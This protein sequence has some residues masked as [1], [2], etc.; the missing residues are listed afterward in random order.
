MLEKVDLTKKIE[1][2]EYKNIIEKL[3]LKI[4]ELQREAKELKIPVII[5][6]EGWKAAGKGTLI[7]EL[8][9]P[10][11]PR[12]FNV[13]P[14]NPPNEEESLRP[15]LWRFWIKTPAKGRIALF[16]R[17]WY[18]RVLT[19][20]I[21]NAVSK[22]DWKLAY[23]EIKSFERQLADAGNV[24]IKLFLHIDKKEQ[25]KRF[26]KLLENKSTSWKI[27]KVDMKA[28]KQYGE[29]LKVFDDMIAKTD[30]DYAPWTIVESHDK[31]FALVK[32][33][34]T[35]IE[36]LENKIAQVKKSKTEKTVKEKTRQSAESNVLNSSILDKIDLSQK[37]SKEDYKINLEQ[38]QKR[39]RE[40]E[41]EIYI[42]RIPVIIMFE[43]WDAAGKGGAI[44]RLTQNMDPR[45]YE[46]IPIAAPN[47]IEKAHHY[48]W[49]FWNAIPKAGHICIFDRTWYGRVLVERIEGFCSTEDWKRAYKEINETEEHLTNH[50]AVVV[51]FWLHIDKDEQMRRFQE[52][53]KLEYKQ[54]KITDEDWRNREKWD[55]YKSAVDELL[56]RT[57]PVNAPW[58]V[59]EANDKL[60][61]R[62]KILKTVI[63]AADKK[64]KKKNG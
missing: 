36:S 39:L 27:T 63:D 58:T 62:I 19:D 3:E 15:F 11:D 12:G 44:R 64:L 45:G 43:G 4:G 9:L 47:D 54:W 40:I 50:G 13:Y 51:K 38:Y 7:N 48:L 26:D 33:Y 57:S 61:A 41:H 55:A 10:L 8:I 31:R 60:F 20:R 30:T 59:V 6:F 24:I 53:Q 32:I 42:R 52:R 22:K 5:V 17:S 49:R 34:K 23:D 16:D 28:Q 56:F 2:E 46:V 35:V 21:E 1:K 37:L 29:Y 18:R 25:K 14:T